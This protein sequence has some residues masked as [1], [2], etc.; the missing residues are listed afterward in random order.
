MTYDSQ[1]RNLINNGKL[2]GD[3]LRLTEEDVI[4]CPPPLFHCF[5]LVM[6]VLGALT[7]GSSL[8]FPSSQFNADLILDSVE[9]E[10]CTVLYGVPTMFL[11]ELEAN[12]RRKRNTSSLKTALAAGSLVPQAVMKRMREEMNLENVLIAYGMTETSP[13]TFATGFE[14]P[15]EYRLTSVGTVF[16][17]TKAKIIDSE[18]N[19]VPRGVRGEICT[20]GYGLQKGYLNNPEKTAEAMRPDSDGVLWMHTGDE[21]VI[22]HLGYCRVTGRIKDTI[23]RGMLN[24]IWTPQ[25]FP[26]KLQALI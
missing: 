1:Y 21:G 17:H 19:I 23:I 13:V 18:G 25:S 2:V 26:C 6:G 10:K 9:F 24:T 16:P 4:C 5:G 8:V 12:K 7:H 14:D 3:Q 15:L 11:V 20:S 22:D